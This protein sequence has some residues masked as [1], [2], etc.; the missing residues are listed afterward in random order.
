MIQDIRELLDFIAE[1]P[2]LVFVQ[3]TLF[4]VIPILAI[5]GSVR[6]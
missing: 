3:A 4:I 1:E 5:C 2:V 6:S